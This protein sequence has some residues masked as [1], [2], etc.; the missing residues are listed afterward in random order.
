MNR[1]IYISLTAF[2]LVNAQQASAEKINHELNFNINQIETTPGDNIEVNTAIYTY[3]FDKLS[4]Y[5][6][7]YT[8][9]DFLG[10]HNKLGFSFQRVNTSYSPE[11]TTFNGRVFFGRN[12]TYGL[13][14]TRST[15]DIDIDY[16]GELTSFEFL[17]NISKP[18]RLSFTYTQYDEE[19]TSFFGGDLSTTVY[20]ASYE[21]VNKLRQQKYFYIGVTGSIAETE[22]TNTVSVNSS[23][24]VSSYYFNREFSIDYINYNEL[25]ADS[26]TYDLLD[27]NSIGV[28]HYLN[29]YFYYQFKF[30]R[31]SVDGDNTDSNSIQIGTR[32]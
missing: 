23:T 9:A 6:G 27:Q 12:R 17:V 25:S 24:L 19:D 13:G 30:T 14:F 7:P 29:K 11:Q 2:I 16:S 21:I 4:S 22:T 26:N 5:Y 28:T 20:S 3:Y 8:Q 15:L 18:S 31:A 32:F 1:I 10:R